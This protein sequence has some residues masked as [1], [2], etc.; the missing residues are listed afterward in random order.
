MANER[1]RHAVGRGSY[2][3]QALA[4][5]NYAEPEKGDM[6]M[7]LRI[8]RSYA[9]R[10]HTMLHKRLPAYHLSLLASSKPSC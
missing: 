2:K 7:N 6:A 1:R 10:L 5:D 9:V 4:F 8:L 3:V